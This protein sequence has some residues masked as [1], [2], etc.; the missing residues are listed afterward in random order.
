M[1]MVFGKSSWRNFERGVEREWLLTNGIGGFASSTII[2]ANTRRYHGLL[3]ASLKPPVQRHLIISQINESISI[4]NLD[5]DLYSF[6]TPGCVLE[7]FRYLQKFEFDSIPGFVYAVEDVLV[8][9]KVCMVYGKNTVCITYHIINGVNSIKIRLAPLVNFRDYHGESRRHHMQFSRKTCPNGIKINPYNLDLT[10]GIYC[11]EGTFIKL[12]DCWFYNMQY[13]IEMER[14]LN[15]TEDHYIPGYFE[16]EVEPGRDMHITLTA[17]V[18]EDVNCLDGRKVIEAERKRIESIIGAS[19]F[20]DPFA[21]SLVEAAD[22]FI[23]YRKSTN[24]KTIIAGY[25]WFTD[26][27][28]D[29]MIALTGLTLVTGRFEDAKQILYTFSKYI[30]DGLVPNMFPDE[31]EEPAYNSVDAALWYVEAAGKFA[32][33]TKDYEF[34]KDK[35]YAILK[36]IIES[37]VK[38]TRFGI[39]MDEDYLITTG[40]E[41]T[42]L[43]W[44]DARVDE[45]VV[46]PRHGKPVEV[47]A[48]WYNAL[49]VMESF[50]CTFGENP[51][52][53]KNMAE[54][55]K[56]SFNEKFWYE[57][58]QYLYDVIA[59]NYKDAS[60]R[61]NQILSVSLPYA[62]IEGEKAQKVVNRVWKDLYIPYG[63]R[64]LSCNCEG[65]KGTYTGGR[66]ERDGSY[67]QGTAWSWLLG[68]FITAFIKVNHYSESSRQAALKLFI[69]PVRDHLQDACLGSISE[70]FDGDYPFCPRGCFAQAWGVGEIL[71]AYVEDIFPGITLSDSCEKR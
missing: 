58:G 15:Y 20:T 47:N 21:A 37:Y 13:P 22:R 50:A 63:L 39:R 28:R 41:N 1:A 51:D 64:S 17:T 57:E 34:I 19:G 5:Y 26:W 9:K 62:V 66:Y 2:G 7:G 67:H 44:M 24:A 56:S 4:N 18:E 8:E 36:E 53:Y 61:P 40:D 42:Q 31:G 25:P 46:T 60:I 11:T 27:G 55:M 38:G 65:Y 69:D 45:W 23:V 68:H 6:K 12:E 29:T 49:K 16:V 71:R 54:K 35:I 10:I 33:Y 48:L 32:E 59:G 3:I 30:R 43:T 14:G 52:Y 70:I